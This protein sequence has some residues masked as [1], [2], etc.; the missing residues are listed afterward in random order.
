MIVEVKDLLY[1]AEE[2]LDGLVVIDKFLR[3][4]HDFVNDERNVFTV[5]SLR[6]QDLSC[7][8]HLLFLTFQKFN[9]FL[10][11]DMSFPIFLNDDGGPNLFLCFIFLHN[12]EFNEYIYDAIL[13]SI[14]DV[15]L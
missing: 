12:K 1:V 9:K 3:G 4:Y 8:E 5:F 14:R 2:I 11:G 10:A 6:L 15:I 7:G 13:M